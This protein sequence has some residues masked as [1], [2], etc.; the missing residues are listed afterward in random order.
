M[1]ELTIF[2]YLPG[3]SA[4]HR[5]DGR[6]KVICMILLSIATCAANQILDLFLLTLLLLPTLFGSALPI[7]KFLI[8]LKYFLFLIG[9]VMAV[10]S[11]SIPGAPL[12]NFSIVNPTREGLYSGLVFGWRIIL[13]VIMGSILTATTTLST[14]KDAVEWFLR[15]I[16]FIPETKIATMIGLT[17]TLIPLIFDQASEMMEA[18]KARCIEGR[19]SPITRI[20]F[21]TYP[22]LLHTLLR[23]DEMVLAMES[24]CYSGERTKAVFRTKPM[25]WLFLLIAGIVCT[26]VLGHILKFR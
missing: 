24:R 21:L 25:D 23:A 15:P 22:L 17:F 12:T 18:Q 4:I 7:K 13:I 20:V 6:I 3:R 8:Q 10:H 9:L 5:M 14:L 26:V 16:P 19:K 11:F 2:G 1:A